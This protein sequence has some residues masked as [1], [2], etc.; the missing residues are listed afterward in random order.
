HGWLYG[1]HYLPHDIRHRELA[2][3]LS[4]ADTLI[5]LG[6]DPLIVPQHNVLDGINAVRRLLGRTFIDEESCAR[7][8]EALR[9]YRRQWHD[10]LKDWKANQLHDWSSH[11]ADALRMFATGFDDPIAPSQTADRHRQRSRATGTAWGA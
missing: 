6:I 8:L 11:A 1:E 4:R 9:Q 7:G 2:T 3:G 10:R 5:G